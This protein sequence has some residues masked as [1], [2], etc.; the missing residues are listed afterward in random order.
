[1]DDT[2]KCLAI[3]SS[4]NVDGLTASCAQAVLNGFKDKGQE[5]ARACETKTRDELKKGASLYDVYKK[6]GII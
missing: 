3:Q 6:Y 5:V 2:M 4:P 1:M